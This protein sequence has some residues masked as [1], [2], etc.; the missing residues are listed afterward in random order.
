[1]YYIYHIPKIKIGCT[2]NPKNRITQQTKGE[3]EILEIHNDVH[4]ASQRELE[5]QK[6]YGY[7]LDRTTYYNS[8]KE[9]NIKNVIKAGKISAKKQWKEKREIELQ[10]C[11]KGGKINAEKN[12]KVT[13][14][15]DINGNQIMIFKN[16]KI[17]AK[18]VNGF[19]SPL[20]NVLNHPTRTYKG[21][22]W[23]SP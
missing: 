3:Y 2:K 9:F 19:A 20:T 10:K 15:C 5:L 1:M 22:K 16:R 7:N 12:S 17:A 23:I 8:T 13:I 6:Q 11:S 21:Y 4:I 14:M 18:S